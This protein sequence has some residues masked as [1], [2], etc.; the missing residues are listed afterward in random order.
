MKTA[1]LI[2]M[3]TE[4]PYAPGAHQ[5]AYLGT[6]GADLTQVVCGDTEATLCDTCKQNQEKAIY[7]FERHDT[8]T[9]RTWKNHVIAASV[10]EARQTLLNWAGR[11]NVAFID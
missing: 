6:A 3:A 10:S 4:Y 11:K 9:G 1:K 5:Q 2:P 8:E 7:V